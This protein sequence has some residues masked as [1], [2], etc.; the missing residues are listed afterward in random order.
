VF[1]R[2]ARVSRRHLE[3]FAVG[4]SFESAEEYEIT[5]ERL[6]DYASE[7]D[8]QGIHL[9]PE[10]A[11]GEMF[12]DIV[13]S[14][15]HSLSATMRLV[16]RSGFLGET[17]LVGLAID[18]LRFLKP[19]RA[20]DRLRARVEVT[21]VRRSGSDSQRGYLGVRVTT[22]RVADR[23]PVVTQEWTILVPRRQALVAD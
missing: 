14:G 8:P 21:D 20:G 1:A 22:I 6:R 9:D 13:A 3:D 2:S 23:E 4:D 17:P 15:W 7:F 19:V 11:E 10:V 12:G 5:P 18:K 16:V